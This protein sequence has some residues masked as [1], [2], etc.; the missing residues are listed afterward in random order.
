MRL[1]GGYDSYP[2]DIVISPLSSEEIENMI[3]RE[4]NPKVA[5]GLK[6]YAA[7]RENYYYSS[8][9]DKHFI[10]EGISKSQGRSK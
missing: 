1:P 10:S 7:G 8:S 9:E 2:Q 3:Q 6:L 4:K 5:E